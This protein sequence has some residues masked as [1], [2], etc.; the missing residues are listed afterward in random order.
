MGLAHKPEG[1]IPKSRRVRIAFAIVVLVAGFA[2]CASDEPAPVSPTTAAPPPPPS[3][4]KVVCPPGAETTGPVCA[5]R[6]A[7]LTESNQEPFAAVDPWRPGF[8]AIGVNAGHTTEGL[9]LGE[10]SDPSFDMVR[11]DIFVTMDNATTWV[12]RQLPPIPAPASTVEPVQSTVVG[13]PALVFSPD[14]V[15]HV[16]GIVTHSQVN[17]YTVFYISSPDLGVTWGPPRVLSTGTDNDRNWMNRGPD[18]TLYVP[19]QRVGS[20][21]EVAWSTDG[22][23]T[24]NLQDRDQVAADCITVSEV[25]FWE[26]RP[27]LACSRSGTDGYAVEVYEFSPID[28]TLT[29]LASPLDDCIWPKLSVVSGNLFLTGES[30]P[31]VRYTM[32]ADG[33]H[34]W[35]EQANIQSIT[36]HEAT[37]VAWQSSDPWGRLHIMLLGTE[38]TYTVLDGKE[39]LFDQVLRPAATSTV[40][41]PRT[42]APTYG[43][44]Y[45]GISWAEWGGLLA[46]T[47]ESTIRYTLVS[48]A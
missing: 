8:M 25:V 26:A 32:S 3:T 37:G 35:F 16:S 31:G 14:G 4:Y 30:C 47:D 1:N 2:G 23:E 41:M 46:W 6:L 10:G 15:L 40:P 17:G 9:V 24:W 7:S 45:Y 18:G 20:R 44:H 28:G 11:L 19:W 42:I 21:S 34:T 13:D 27:I 22:G 33:G 29:L 12:R 38:L 48:A 39:I 5:G 36:G 43:D